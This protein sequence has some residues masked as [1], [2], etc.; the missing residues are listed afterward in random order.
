MVDNNVSEANN[1]TSVNKVPLMIV[2]ISGAFVAILNQTLLATALP[3]IMADLQ[4]DANTAQWLQSI[5][6][7]VNGIMI[8]ITAF[9]IERFTTRGLFLTALTIFAVGTVICAIAPNFSILMAGRVAQAAAAGIIMPLMQTILF[10]IFPVEKRG[11][12]M[13]MFGLVIAFAPAIG[14]TL[15]GWLVE[16]FPWRSLFYIILPIIIVDIIIAYFILKN[17]TNRTFPKLDMISIVLST[18]GFGGL[19]FGFSSAGNNGWGSFEVIL[20]LVIGAITL[21]FFIWRQMKLEQPILEFRVFKNSIFTLTTVLGM[22]TF[23]AMIGA[24]VVLP[25]LA[26]NML[27][28]TALESGLMLLPGAVLM[29]VMNPI[30]GRLFDK[31]GARWLSI[32]GL[33]IVTVTTFMFSN[34][35]ADTTFT[36]LATVNAIRMFGI[37]MVMMPVTT[38]GLN[39]LPVNLIPHGTAMNNTMRQVAGAVGTALLVSVMTNSAIPEEGLN[40]MIHGVNVSFIVAGVFAII[41]LILSFFIKRS[42]PKSVQI[43]K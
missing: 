12:A 38:A 43:S 3:H 10:L 32:I 22:V 13:G 35:S 36:Y 40:G 7:L 16:H 24:A 6:M 17:I 37:A 20:S 15:S 31:F 26:Q 2:L 21:F 5:F 33:T 27:G 25:L 28:F 29:G 9:L 41:A 19:L 1:P 30:T 42:Q 4:L 14:P 11:S 23:I 8:P 18:L 39:Q 34:L